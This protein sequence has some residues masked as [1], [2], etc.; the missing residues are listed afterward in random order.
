MNTEERKYLMNNIELTL[1]SG[2]HKVGVKPVLLDENY[3]SF[4]TLNK[5]IELTGKIKI[6]LRL[7]IYCKLSMIIHK[8]FIGKGIKLWEEIKTQKINVN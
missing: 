1:V 6:P 3:I 2:E 4:E 8:L 7:R 5:G